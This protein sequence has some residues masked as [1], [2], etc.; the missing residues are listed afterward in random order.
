MTAVSCV[1]SGL[2]VLRED[3][4]EVVGMTTWGS[5]VAVFF[6]CSSQLESEKK[7]TMPLS[8]IFQYVTNRY[9]DV[10]LIDSLDCCIFCNTASA[11]I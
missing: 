1:E 3:E 11:T 2:S 5:V 4:L 6:P 8:S 10:V 7:L 9:V